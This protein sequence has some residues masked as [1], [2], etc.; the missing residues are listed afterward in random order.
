MFNGINL[1]LTYFKIYIIDL[2]I[3]ARTLQ[4][5]LDYLFLKIPKIFLWYGDVPQHSLADTVIDY[6]EEKILTNKAF[7]LY[8][9][10]CPVFVC[11]VQMHVTGHSELLLEL[12]L[13]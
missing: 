4:I 13:C 1:H 2:Y 7:M 10:S 9:I 5:F 6:E 3:I 12:H 11:I 8:D